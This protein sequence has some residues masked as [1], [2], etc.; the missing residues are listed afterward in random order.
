MKKIFKKFRIG[1]IVVV[2]ALIVTILF[3]QWPQLAQA[4]VFTAMSDTMTRLKVSE[5]ADHTAK[6]TL[7]ATITFDS[8]TNTDILRV[9]FPHSSAFTQSGTWVVGDF[10]FNDGT[11]RTV[12]AV[13]QGAGTIDCTV[14]A[15]VD[16]VCVAIDTTNHIFSIKPSADYNASGAAAIITFTID[17]TDTDGTLTNPSGAASYKVDLAM[18]DEQAG[19]ITTFVSTHTGAVAVPIITDEQV[20][21][22]ATVDPSITFTLS[23]NTA[24]LGTLSSSAISTAAMTVQTI[25][26]AIS[27]YSTTVLEDN[28]LRIDVSNDID[29]TTGNVDL[30]SE[31]YGMATTDNTPAQN[32]AY[33]TAA[34]CTTPPNPKTA[35]AITSSVQTTAG[36]ATGPVDETNTLCFA[37]SITATT[38]AGS[39]NHTLTFVS[40]GTF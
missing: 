40:T 15:G 31:E 30:G 11:P 12:N 37:A 20:V 6:W 38:T 33:D 24:D 21:V 16:N 2:V 29:D 10:T 5:T 28:N 4:A 35:T 36:E 32:I 23:A 17:G 19:C 3:L 25:T 14:A 34:N 13:A 1:E 26:N 9:D 39:Y 7:P 22:S 27:G 8:S 18:C